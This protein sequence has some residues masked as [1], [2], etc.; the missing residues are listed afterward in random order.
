MNVRAYLNLNVKDA[1]HFKTK[2]YR[3]GVEQNTF[4]NIRVYE[5]KGRWFAEIY[6]LSDEFP[7]AI[8]N[9]I[10]EVS[11]RGGH[12]I[13][14]RREAGVYRHKTATARVDVVAPE[15]YSNRSPFRFDFNIRAKNL[16]DLRELYHMI[17]VGSIRP[18]ESYDGPQS[19]MSRVELEAEFRELR[20]RAEELAAKAKEAAEALVTNTLA[21]EIAR[22]KLAKI[23][24]LA[25]RFNDHGWL[26][27]PFVTKGSV[28]RE[29]SDILY[30]RV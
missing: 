9:V 1:P 6:D 27:K 15:T 25:A 5:E 29:L 10:E 8:V 16:E 30:D 20:S 11:F 17:R 24:A 14:A 2:K 28:W 18:E 12:Q 26:A 19:G 3:D 23:S 21:L 7:Q 22:R 13:N 4:H